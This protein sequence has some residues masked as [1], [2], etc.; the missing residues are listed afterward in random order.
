MTYEGYPFVQ[1]AHYRS[2]RLATPRFVVVHTIES[3]QMATTGAAVA[4]WF[5]TQPADDPNPTS[6][7]AMADNGHVY[8][9]VKDEDTAY[10]CGTHGNRYGLGIEHAGRAA[11]TAADWDTPY[12]DAMLR[13]SA[14]Q[15]ATWCKK[16]AIPGRRINSQDL[17]A[18]RSGICGHVDVRDAWPA[19]TTHW[20]PGTSWPWS[21]HL[22]YITAAMGGAPVPVPVPP[23]RDAEEEDEEMSRFMYLGSDGAAVLVQDNTQVRLEPLAANEFS[24][25]GVIYVNGGKASAAQEAAYAAAY[26]PVHK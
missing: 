6:A 4:A 16:Y 26:G 22:A 20:D 13:Q 25:S 18:G 8:R 12:T 21:K 15:I 14:A 19:D 2:G 3:A 11:F 10:H 5:A 24:S 9:M 23:P 1:A 17:L 7:H